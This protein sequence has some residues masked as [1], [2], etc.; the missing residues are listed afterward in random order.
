MNLV[1]FVHRASL[2]LL[3]AVKVMLMEASVPAW[4][5]EAK[6]VKLLTPEEFSSCSPYCYLCYD[7][8][9]R[10]LSVVDE[11]DAVLDRIDVDDMIGA[12]IELELT[13]ES[14]TSSHKHQVASHRADN[15]PPTDTLADRKGK[16]VLI[17]YTYPRLMNPPSRWQSIFCSK[18]SPSPNPNYQRPPPSPALR[19]FPR[20]AHPRRF[21]LAPVEDFSHASKL[22]AALHQYA[23]AS[24]SAAAAPKYLILVNPCSGPK[25]DGAQLVETIVQ[26]MLEQAGVQCDVCITQYANH[27]TDKVREADLLE[28]DGIVLLGGDGIIHETL[29]GIMDRKDSQQVLQK[30]KFGVVGC[31]TGNGFATSVARQ[32]HELYGPI[33]ETYLIA[34]GRTVRADLSHYQTTSNSYTSFLTYTWAMIADIDIESERIHWLGEMRFDVWAVLRV[35]TMRRYRGRLSYLPACSTSSSSTAGINRNNAPSSAPCNMP[36]LNQPVPKDWKVLEDDF[37]LFWT[38]HIPDAAVRRLRARRLVFL[39]FAV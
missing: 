37:V 28:Y 3:V 6:R 24:S 34:K 29:N 22:C 20:V 16:A 31:G 10:I 7:E 18:S 1:L 12:K 26:P 35:L 17:L 9:D 33:N 8:S 19:R 11:N 4:P 21:P 36:A 2:L 13:E 23:T 32:S 5:A 27:A 15:E 14:S 38:S 39:S 25:K 30:L